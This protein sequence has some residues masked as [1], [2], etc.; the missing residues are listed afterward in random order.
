VVSCVWGADVNQG[1]VWV[2]VGASCGCA[3]LDAVD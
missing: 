2:R 3:R 1:R